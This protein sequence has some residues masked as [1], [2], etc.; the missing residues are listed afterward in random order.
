MENNKQIPCKECIA[1]AMCIARAHSLKL[2]FN[3]SAI[4]ASIHGNCST[5]RAYFKIN[6]I[7]TLENVAYR[8][9]PAG[10]EL[11]KLFKMPT[12]DYG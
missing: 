9:Q 11:L 4:V 6:E 12:Y 5:L 8:N 3:T 7:D 1:L 2:V 10:K